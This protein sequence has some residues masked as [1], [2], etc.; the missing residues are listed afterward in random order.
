MARSCFPERLADSLVDLIRA[1]GRRRRDRPRRRALSRLYPRAHRGRAGLGPARAAANECARVFNA[2]LCDEQADA[3]EVLRPPRSAFTA[4]GIDIRQSCLQ[5]LKDLRHPFADGRFEY[6][7]TFE[8]MQAA[9]R[10][11]GRRPNAPNGGVGRLA[12]AAKRLARPERRPRRR[13]GRGACARGTGVSPESLV[14]RDVHQPRPRSVALRAR[15]ARRSLRSARPGAGGVG[16]GPSRW[17][18]SP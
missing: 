13:V 14:G 8:N 18:P 5:I 10:T 12:L 17:T 1:P 16:A 6:D 9:E 15:A 3:H 11:S 2:R 7:V 4:G